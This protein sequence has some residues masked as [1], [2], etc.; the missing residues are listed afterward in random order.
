MCVCGF[1]CPTKRERIRLW[2]KLHLNRIYCAFGK[3][4]W[5]IFWFFSFRSDAFASTEAFCAIQTIFFSKVR[6]LFHHFPPTSPTR[7]TK[8]KCLHPPMNGET[9]L[10]SFNSLFFSPTQCPLRCTLFTNGFV[11]KVKHLNNNLKNHITKK[12]T[13]VKKNPHTHTPLIRE[14]QHRGELYILDTQTRQHHP[15]HF[16][17]LSPSLLSSL[18]SPTYSFKSDKKKKKTQTN[19]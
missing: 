13:A 11:F 14:E 16:N 15:L 3:Y 8:K 7:R 17:L 19:Q 9:F 18:L 5:A 2:T 6:I 12:K 1:L 4:F 10:H